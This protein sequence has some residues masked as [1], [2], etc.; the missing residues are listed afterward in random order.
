[1]LEYILN[2]IFK[3]NF[4]EKIEINSKIKYDCFFSRLL[5]DDSQHVVVD[6]LFLGWRI[7]R[8]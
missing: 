4:Q 5:G 6:V 1:M 8:Y 7:N 3:L 2:F